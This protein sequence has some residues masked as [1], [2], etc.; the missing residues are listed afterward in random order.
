MSDRVFFLKKN[1]VPMLKLRL[2]HIENDIE[3]TSI[4]FVFG[5]KI[6][7]NES[8]VLTTK[9]FS[10]CLASQ[11]VCDFVVDLTQHF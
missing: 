9:L 1:V 5:A 8:L 11:Q 7:F 4:T 10:L 2:K 3:Q 6:H